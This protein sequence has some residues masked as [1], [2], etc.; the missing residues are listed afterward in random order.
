MF[1]KIEW[2]TQRAVFVL[3]MQRSVPHMGMGLAP[4]PSRE[5]FVARQVILASGCAVTT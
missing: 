1:E 2:T 3:Y 5:L 4:S